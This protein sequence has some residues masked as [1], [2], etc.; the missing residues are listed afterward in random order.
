MRRVDCQPDWKT[1]AD[2]CLVELIVIS[3]FFLIRIKAITVTLV[4]IDVFFNVFLFLKLLLLNLSFFLEVHACKLKF[5]CGRCCHDILRLWSQRRNPLLHAV[6]SQLGSLLLAGCYYVFL[7][8]FSIALSTFIL[9][10]ASILNRVKMLIVPP[11]HCLQPINRR[12]SGT[13]FLREIVIGKSESLIL[14]LLFLGGGFLTC[15]KFAHRVFVLL[16]NIV[17][18]LVLLVFYCRILVRLRNAFSLRKV[19]GFTLFRWMFRKTAAYDAHAVIARV[20]RTLFVTKLQKA[21]SISQ[22]IGRWGFHL[23]MLMK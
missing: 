12:S 13:C 22:I 15:R 10:L 17:I 3:G 16:L 8:R 11:R 19:T 7:N 6:P 9:Y 23:Y 2:G 21:I 1:A 14:E 4:W 18:L 5:T 20:S